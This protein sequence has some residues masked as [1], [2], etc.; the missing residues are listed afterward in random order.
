MGHTE[1]EPETAMAKVM[2]DTIYQAQSAKCVNYVTHLENDVMP[3]SPVLGN[4]A[5]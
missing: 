5:E 1:A 2:W 4:F 3:H